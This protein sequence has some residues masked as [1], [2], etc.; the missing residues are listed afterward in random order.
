MGRTF[1]PLSA[2]SPTPPA[3]AAHPTPCRPRKGLPRLLCPPLSAPAMKARSCCHPHRGPCAAPPLGLGAPVGRAG[4]PPVPL[5][6]WARRQCSPCHPLGAPS[7]SGPPPL[8]TPPCLSHRPQGPGHQWV[9]APHARQAAHTCFCAGARTRHAGLASGSSGVRPWS[10]HL[11]AA[12]RGYGTVN[13]DGN[14]TESETRTGSGSA[15]GD[16]SDS[17]PH[18]GGSGSWSESWSGSWRSLRQKRR[19]RRS[20]GCRWGRGQVSAGS[21]PA[22]PALDP[23][24]WPGVGRAA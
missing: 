4:Q 6:P 13:S 21:G 24:R 18:R 5:H 14:G 20:G 11:S 12:D 17:S 16:L 23:P 2:L 3:A 8:R 22:P 9:P 15:R 19:R 7:Q 10:P 1:Q